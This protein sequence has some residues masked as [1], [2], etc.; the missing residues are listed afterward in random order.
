[1]RMDF[2]SQNK[3]YIDK[4]ETMIKDYQLIYKTSKETLEKK[5]RFTQIHNHILKTYRE[6]LAEY[7]INFFSEY[8]IQ[9]NENQSPQEYF[10]EHNIDIKKQVLKLPSKNVLNELELYVLD[11]NNYN[12]ISINHVQNKCDIK[13]HATMS[14]LYTHSIQLIYYGLEVEDNSKFS[15]ISDKSFNIFEQYKK[16]TTDLLELMILASIQRRIISTLYIVNQY[17]KSKNI[18]R[19]IKDKLK[20]Y[21]QANV[22]LFHKSLKTERLRF[23]TDQ[24]NYLTSDIYKIGLSY[25]YSGHDGLLYTENAN[26]LDKILLFFNIHKLLINQDLYTSDNI[27][28]ISSSPPF[29]ENLLY[30]FYRKIFNPIGFS[31]EESAELSLKYYQQKLLKSNKE[32]KK[33]INKI[34]ETQ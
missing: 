11:S 17:S 16:N 32:I 7:F 28:L 10:K 31:L 20:N 18:K 24:I 1:M 14:L 4:Y 22:E 6:T 26:S 23:I 8:A 21:E 2:N 34:L 30:R 27:K 15:Q 12:C 9:I 3:P 19:Y 33:L 13:S 25:F 5:K 29:Q